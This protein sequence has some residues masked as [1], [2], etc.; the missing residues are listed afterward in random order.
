LVKT[1]VTLEDDLYKKLAREALEKYGRTRSLSKLINEKL[2]E[3]EGHLNKGK[4]ADIIES[5]FGSW[6]TKETGAQYVKKLRRE[7]EK[8]FE[9]LGIQS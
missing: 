4:A 5:A 3:E 2:K 8:R 1:T 6:K 9:R 7:S